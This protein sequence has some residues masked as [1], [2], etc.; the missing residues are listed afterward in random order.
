MSLLYRQAPSFIRPSIVLR[1]NYSNGLHLRKH[2]AKQSHI[3]Y[4]TFMGWGYEHLFAKSG[5]HD[6]DSRHVLIRYNPFKSLLFRDKVANGA[7]ARYAALC[8]WA[9]ESLKTYNIRL[10]FTLSL[11]DQIYFY[12]D[13]YRQI[14]KNV[15]V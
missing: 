5:S 10:T 13:S 12:V 2:C 14:F 11:N 7:G 9:H 3:L 15:L 4:G 1:P 8:A 6:Q